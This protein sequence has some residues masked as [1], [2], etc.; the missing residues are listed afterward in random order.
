MVNVA[1]ALDRRS[2]NGEGGWC[3]RVG[4][5]CR[6]RRVAQELE[7]AGEWRMENGECWS[8]GAITLEGIW[9]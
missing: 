6:G 9:W 1:A 5:A 4:S 3:S 8:E 7:S 2:S